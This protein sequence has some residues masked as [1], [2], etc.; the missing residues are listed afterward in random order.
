MN[1][2]DHVE[3]YVAHKR[4]LG[5]RYEREERVLYPW[6]TTAMSCGQDI[7]C[8]DTMIRWAQQASSIN[9]AAKTVGYR[10]SVCTLA[11]YRR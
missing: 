4:S 8:A 10:A 6:A 2:K 1:M 5:Y 9:E 11:S 3:C 7:T